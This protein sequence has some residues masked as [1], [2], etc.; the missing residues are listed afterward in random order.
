MTVAARC[1]PSTAGVGYV[2]QDSALFPHL[3]VAGNIGFGM[4]RRSRAGLAGA[5]SSWSG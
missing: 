1:E 3:T 5:R 4:P 2:P